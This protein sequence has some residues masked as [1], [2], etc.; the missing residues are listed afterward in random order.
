MT[1][2]AISLTLSE[3]QIKRADEALATLETLFA[4]FIELSSAEKRKLAKMGD[5]SEAFCRQTLLILGQNQ[6]MLPPDFDLAEAQRD[7][8]ALE[9]LRPLLARLERITTK[10]SDTEMALGSDVISA[11]FEGYALAK[12]IGKG[13]PLESLRQAMSSRFSRRPGKGDTPAA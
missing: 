8:A 3:E 11:A 1:Q 12:V 5:K 6:G 7:M 10:A 9:A 2:N 4:S 13:A